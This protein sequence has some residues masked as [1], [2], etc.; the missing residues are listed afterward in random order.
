MKSFDQPRYPGSTGQPRAP[1]VVAM[2]MANEGVGR[3]LRDSFR[4][5][6]LPDEMA[7]LLSRMR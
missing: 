2:P 6:A 5:D 7:R 3:A 1:Q 4:C